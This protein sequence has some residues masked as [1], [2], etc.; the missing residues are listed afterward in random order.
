MKYLTSNYHA[1]TPRCKHAYGTEREYIEAAIKMGIKKFGFSDHVPCPYKD[2]FV[3]GIRMPMEEAKDYVEEIRAL[4]R[5]YQEQ[6]ELFVGFETE[7]V[8]EY[9]KEQM[10][11]F[12]KLDCD[13]MIM[14]Q[15]FLT[16]EKVGPY[17]GTPTE[18]EQFLIAYVDRIIEGMKTGGFLY[19]AHPDIINYQGSEA[20]YDREMR[21]LCMELKEL[22]IPLEI[23]LLGI[24]ERKQ[25]PAERFWKIVG[26]VGNDVVFGLDVHF[27]DQIDDRETYE[28][29]LALAKKFH[30]HILEDIAIKE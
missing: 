23:N 24:R 12:K 18:D 19:L 22:H 15:H 13:Y 4:A 26:E 21:R 3:S 7:Y 20:V 2:G 11:L 17:T 14:G 8:P 1:H 9:F 6:I 28:A 30:L 5:E 29:G 10:E 25:Y 27:I 16:N